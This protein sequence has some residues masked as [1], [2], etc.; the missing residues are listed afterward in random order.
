MVLQRDQNHNTIT[1]NTDSTY[2]KIILLHNNGLSLNEITEQLHISMSK[3]RKTLATEGIYVTALTKTIN[4]LYNE[5]LTQ[6]EIAAKLNKSI[7]AIN[8]H[9]RYTK[10]IYNAEQR[11]ANALRIK[12]HRINQE[13][14]SN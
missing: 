11:S 1:A 10:C 7:K 12:K 8:N 6:A 14:R 5:G 13:K 2:T 9:L 4:Q 3:A